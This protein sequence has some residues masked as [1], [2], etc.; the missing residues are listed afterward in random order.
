[1]DKRWG[2]PGWEAKG[3]TEIVMV[4]LEIDETIL[5]EVGLDGATLDG[6]YVEKVQDSVV[7]SV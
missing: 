6:L 1:M 3:V 4:N 5:L 2:R 7:R